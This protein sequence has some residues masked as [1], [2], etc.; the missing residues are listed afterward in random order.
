MHHLKF[1]I[2]ILIKIHNLDFCKY[3]IKKMSIV[4]ISGKASKKLENIKIIVLNRIMPLYHYPAL[5]CSIYLL[6]PV[7]YQP[8]SIQYYIGRN[9]GVLN[10]PATITVTMAVGGRVT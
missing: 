9:I 3:L 10:H 5:Q 6:E 7:S 4:Q 2:E 8:G 1:N